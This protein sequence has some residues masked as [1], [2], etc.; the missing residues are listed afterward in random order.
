MRRFFRFAS[1]MR[2]RE[3]DPSRAIESPKLP[4][5]LPRYLELAEIE[6]LVAATGAMPRRRGALARAALE[7][8]FASGL[9]VSEMLALRREALAA[10]GAGVLL[11]RGKGGRERL[12]PFSE[13]ARAALADLPKTRAPRSWLFPGRDPARPMTRQ[14]LAKLLKEVALAA[15][16]DPARLSPHVLRHSFATHLLAGGADL[17]AVQ[18]LLGHASITTTEIYTHLA[19]ER[20]RRVVEAHH[21]LGEAGRGRKQGP[22]ADA[23]GP[24]EPDAQGSG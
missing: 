4:K 22:S 5:S 1:E 19:A 13:A 2:W 11:I 6:A 23:L 12:V 10:G 21:P 7:L 9:R 24:E 16:I 17:R 20:L 8:L 15:G 14:G 3:D 18:A